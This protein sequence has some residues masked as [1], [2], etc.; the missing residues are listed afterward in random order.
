MPTPPTLTG[1][2]IL[3][4]SADYD[5]ARTNFNRRFTHTPQAM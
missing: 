1:R 4:N 2:V 5:D 3:P